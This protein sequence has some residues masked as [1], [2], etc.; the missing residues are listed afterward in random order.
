M[1]ATVKVNSQIN[2]QFFIIHL[3]NKHLNANYSQAQ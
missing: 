2:F 3:S 1:E